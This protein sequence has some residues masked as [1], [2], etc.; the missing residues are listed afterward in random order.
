M[1]LL[2]PS[3]LSNDSLFQYVPSRT[4]CEALCCAHQSFQSNPITSHA[5]HHILQMLMVNWV[6]CLC[7]VQHHDDTISVGINQA[8]DHHNGVPDVSVCNESTLW[9]QTQCGHW[10]P[11]PPCNHVGVHAVVCI[12]DCD[13]LCITNG[14]W[15]VVVG[16][17]PHLSLFPWLW[18]PHMSLIPKSSPARSPPVT[19]SCS[20]TPFGGLKDLVTSKH[21]VICGDWWRGFQFTDVLMHSLFSLFTVNPDSFEP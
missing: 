11:Q 14:L 12:V 18:H 17:E 5:K 8:V 20:K 16:D 21:S 7:P 13:V 19:T 3:M 2:T 6:I 9:S 1:P 4:Q 10:F 15:L